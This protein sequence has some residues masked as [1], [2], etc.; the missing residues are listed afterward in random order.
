MGIWVAFPLH[1]WVSGRCSN[2]G[3]KISTLESSELYKDRKNNIAQWIIVNNVGSVL[4]SNLDT[5][6]SFRC[7]NLSNT[8]PYTS[9]WSTYTGP[10]FFQSIAS[11]QVIPLHSRAIRMPYP[12]GS[13]WML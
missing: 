3:A 11:E 8:T 6:W 12:P 13:F 1:T 9:L 5:D 2:P 10:T 7:M 4:A